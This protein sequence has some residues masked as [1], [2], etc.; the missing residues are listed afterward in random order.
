M[1]SLVIGNDGMVEGWRIFFRYENDE[2]LIAGLMREMAPNPASMHGPV[3][4]WRP[5]P[6]TR[7]GR[8]HT[9]SGPACSQAYTV[10]A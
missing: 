3:V 4:S 8:A 7:T 9:R 2:P 1:H 5:V 10:G 6:A